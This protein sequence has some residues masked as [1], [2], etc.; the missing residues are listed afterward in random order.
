MQA[1]SHCL[2]FEDYWYP[3]QELNLDQQLRRL[4][5]YPLRHGGTPVQ[6]DTGT[7]L[8]SRM[9]YYDKCASLVNCFEPSVGKPVK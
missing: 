1:I 2:E 9:L 6:N 8:G 4:L 7:I 5:R 3:R